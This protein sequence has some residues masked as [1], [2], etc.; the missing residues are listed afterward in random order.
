MKFAR[1]LAVIVV[2]CA[3]ARALA[4]ATPDVEQGL[5][6]F[7]SYH[8]GSLDNVNLTNGNLFFHADLFSYS[9]RGGELAYP[10][11]LQYNG[12]NFSMYQT[13]CP[14]GTK[15]GAGCTLQLTILFG[16]NQLRT[17]KISIGNSVTIGYEGLPGVG[18]GNLDT[19]LSYD[20]TEIY[21]HPYSVVMPNGSVR[22]MVTTGTG[23]ASIDGSG[24]F[25]PSP[26]NGLLRSR[27]GTKYTWVANY[28]ED[29]NGN[30]ISLNSGVWEDTLGRQIPPAPTMPVP[31]G[32]PNPSTASLSSCPLLNYSFQPVTYAYTWNL[33]TINGGTLPLVVCYSSVFVRTNI[34]GTP[35]TGPNYFDVNQAFPMLQSVVFPDNTYWAFQYDAADPNNTSSFAFGDL[36][37]V[38]LPT[39]GTLAYSWAP[40][41]MGCNATFDRAVQTRTVNANDGAGPHT[42][43]YNYAYGNP[44]S[45]VTVTDPLGNNAV[46]TITALG[47]ELLSGGGPSCT[48]YETK[49]QYYQGS[50]S[51]GTLLKTLATDYQY[52]ANPYDPAVISS[53]GAQQNATTVTNVFPIRVT[54]TLPNGLVSKT[55]TDYDTSL[56]YHGPLD[57]ITWNV[58]CSTGTAGQTKTYAPSD[59]PPSGT[60]TYTATQTNPVTNYTGSYGKAIATR[61]YDWA[62]GAPG[63]LLRQ[64]TTSYLWQSNANYLNNNFL[65]LVST[66]TTKDGAGNQVAQTTYGYDEYSLNPSGASTQFNT[67]PANGS[68]RGNQTSVHRWLNGTTATTTNCNVS[69]SNGYVVS[70]THYNDSGTLYT[71]TDACASS[72]TDPNHTTT[73]G[74]SSTFAYA[75]PTSVTNPLQQ[76]ASTNYDFNTGLVTATT[77]VNGQTTTTSYD[78]Y[79][80]PAEVDYPDQGQ[81]NFCYTDAGGG[82]NCTKASSSPYAVVITRKL[83]T[84]QNK[85]A[86]AVVDGLGRKTEVQ[87]NTDPACSPYSKTDFGYDAAGRLATVTNPFCTTSDSTYGVTTTSYDALGRVTQVTHPDGTA[88]T[89][90]YT[91]RAV[92]V[93]DE[94]NGTRSVQRISQSDGLG[95]LASV[96]EVSSATQ[97]FGSGAAPAACSLDISATG[98][99]TTYS[100]DTLGNLTG[101]SQGGYMA[102]S[103]TYD[104][105]S[106]LLTATNPESGTIAYTYDAAG[107]VITRKD[108]R[109][110]TTTYSPD[111]LHRVQSKSYSDGT[112][113]ATFTYDVC[114]AG[115][116]P[117]GVSP[118]LTTGRLVES[119]VP[120][121]QTFYSYDP[122]GRVLNQWQCTPVNCG[123]SFYTLAY[124]YDLAGDPTSIANGFGTT[125]SSM[126]D[127]ATRLTGVTSNI[128]DSSH[129]ANLLSAIQYNG[130]GLPKS[131]SLGNT[132]SETLAYDNRLR[133]TSLNASS[134]TAVGATY[135]TGSVTVNGSE[136]S[137]NTA[138]TAATGS[139]TINGSERS[140][141]KQSC[142]QQGSQRICTPYTVYDMGPVTITVN[143]YQVSYTFGQN[144]TSATV[145]S[146]LAGSLNSGSPVTA[147]VSGSTIYLTSNVTGTTGNY[148]LAVSASSQAGFS[149][150]SFSISASGGSLSGGVNAFTTYDSGTVTVTIN[151]T[152]ASASYGSSSTSSSLASALATALTNGT[153]VNAT[154]SANVVSITSKA[155]GSAANYSLAVSSSSSAGFSPVSFTETDSG[156]ALSGGSGATSGP[157]YIVSMSYAPNSN[158]LSAQDTVNGNW[159]Y[160]YDD[161]N[162]LASSNKNSGQQT[163]TYL[164][165]RFGNRWQQNAP[166]G[167][168]TF[169]ATFNG[170][171]NRMDSVN[172]DA[173]G[174]VTK[175]ATTGANYTFDAESRIVGVSSS[176]ESVSYSYDAGGQRVEKIVNGVKTDYVYDLGGHAIAEISGSGT[177]NRQE[178]FANGK[179]LGTYVTNTTYFSHGDWLGTERVRSDMTGAACETIQGLPFGDGQIISGTCGDP[180]TRHFTGK[181]RD[182]ETNLDYFGARY[183]GSSMGEFITPDWAAKA[184]AVPYAEFADPQSLNLYSYVRNIPTVKV[185]QDGH[186]NAQAVGM[187]ATAA[188]A[189]AVAEPCG[190]GMGVAGIVAAPALAMVVAVA[191]PPIQVDGGCFDGSCYIQ[192]PSVSTTPTNIPA[193][194]SQTLP[195]KGVPTAISESDARPGTLGKPDHQETVKAEADRINGETEVTIETPNGSKGS[196]RADAVG[197]NQETGAPE[198]VQVYRPTPAGN[199]PKRELDAAQ[200]IENATGV[201][202][203]MVP[204]RPVPKP[205]P[206]PVPQQP[207]AQ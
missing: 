61:E 99:L 76:I 171:N 16:P 150:A 111:K 144:D 138:A 28:A 26:T 27:N 192:P 23:I 160:A 54:T 2:I 62:Q 41:T 9:Q 51:G 154:A 6:P 86:T 170:G 7:G 130:A 146:A 147:S 201:K 88:A 39:G 148:S 34:L 35:A 119:S 74:Y 107:E 82:K 112:P 132:V 43:T 85:I 157:V 103:F 126:Y 185:D 159:T 169:L 131:E 152:A 97:S 5:K 52:T 32:T 113:T 36:L 182:T 37:K 106:D 184:T 79:W 109:A 65:D 24:Y 19:S 191:V 163:Y 129:P 70:Y 91:G 72:P 10:I 56:A 81:L 175:D 134:P 33:P 172:H 31:P 71:S 21:A 38:T 53:G 151:G 95:R 203:T 194:T 40:S 92:E 84:T 156:A 18:A 124:G 67:A 153:L 199:I 120:N 158:V 63:S 83:S 168:N 49:T 46:H 206:Q 78:Q 195:A 142:V 183:Y 143:G 22:Q 173:S 202:P 77:D 200:D 94:G 93:S 89:T 141:T 177:V 110:I 48:L 155:T 204:V 190:V 118:Q 42:W 44:N 174:N 178:L 127:T 3:C 80:R 196:R 125:L 122:M 145:A 57:G 25:S 135:A 11:A 105:L 59:A 115:G 55:E 149:P 45:I 123:T 96:C 137:Y 128:S 187:V 13:P 162:R 98:F 100:Y 140:T 197:T 121:A 164:Y 188:A 104:S 116:C 14:P 30:Q 90:S 87:L 101:V 20:G 60:C 139:V 165:D 181:E 73:F 8:G 66:A 114:P 47:E 69:V 189:C 4:Q 136:R 176:S 17:Q 1:L 64:T 108:A 117:T 102:R 50:Q 15:V 75:Y 167:G 12:K 58:G 68:F 29:S 179:H 207:T 180:S 186:Q 166:Q 193:A 161:F 198:I 205:Q 133:M